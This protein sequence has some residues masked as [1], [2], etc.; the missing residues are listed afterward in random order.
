[1]ADLGM[2]Y[3]QSWPKLPVNNLPCRHT[4]VDVWGGV[5]KPEATADAWRGVG[6]IITRMIIHD[7]SGTL[8]SRLWLRNLVSGYSFSSGA[9]ETSMNVDPNLA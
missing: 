8:V 1:M 3:L 5:E 4:D 6:I 9:A 7:F 2:K